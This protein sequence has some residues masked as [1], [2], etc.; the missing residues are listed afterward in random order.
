MMMMMM[1]KMSFNDDNDDDEG[2]GRMVGVGC[3]GGRK[4]SLGSMSRAAAA[5][6]LL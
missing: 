2:L 3:V 5:L 6:F 4:M 1:R